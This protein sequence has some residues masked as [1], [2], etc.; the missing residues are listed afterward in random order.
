MCV[1]FLLRS[2]ANFDIFR[3]P[4]GIVDQEDRIITILAGRPQGQDWDGVQMGMSTEL[5]SA[6]SAIRGAGEERRGKYTS[7]SVGISYGGGQMVSLFSTLPTLLSRADRP[8]AILFTS[9]P[10]RLL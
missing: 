8:L 3:T 7:L 9:L 5:Q 10:T 4:T 2:Y 6:A 1:N